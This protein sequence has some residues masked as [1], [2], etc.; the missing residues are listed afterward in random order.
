MWKTQIEGVWEKMLE[1]L[2]LRAMKWEEAGNNC[3]IKEL[4][5]SYSS[6]NIIRIVK[7]GRMKWEGHLGR[8]AE[9]RNEHR[10]L[11]RGAAGRRPFG[12][13]RP[14]R[15]NNIKIN[16][17]EAAWEDVDWTSGPGKGPVAGGE[18][19]NQWTTELHKTRGISWIAERL[20]AP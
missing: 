6:P 5:N 2:Y 10:L 8:M 11:V 15:R 12:R 13:P 4:H 19:C 20:S 7:K 9:I 18:H 1:H 3:N 16:L 17:T 14:R